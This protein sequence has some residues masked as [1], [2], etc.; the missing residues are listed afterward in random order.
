MKQT[1]SRFSWVTATA[2]VMALPTA[3][4]IAI[5]LFERGIGR[6]RRPY[7]AANPLLER[8]GIKESLG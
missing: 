6:K 2:L 4:F 5:K 3:Y 7:D 1:A 8:M